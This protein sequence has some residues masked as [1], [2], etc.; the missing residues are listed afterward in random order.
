[1]TT[2]AGDV[3]RELGATTTSDGQHQVDAAL[4]GFGDVALD[5]LNLVFLEEGLA[6]R[7]T[8]SGQ[9][10][11]GHAAADEE[12]VGLLQ[13]VGDDAELVGDLGAAEDDAVGALGVTGDL[14]QGLD[15]LED[16]QAGGRGQQLGNVV[17][18][19]LLAVDDTEAVG[20]EGVAELGVLAGQLLALFVDLGGLARVVADVL[21]QGDLALTQ[22]GNR[23][24]SGGPTTSEASVTF[25]PDSSARRVATGA[26]EKAG[27][28]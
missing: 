3:G 23:L 20:D 24:G 27:S 9:E 2:V 17:D 11:E 19:R 5:G 7:V 28:T 18:G 22:G 13:Q 1:M 6:D 25:T 21:E 8:L 14:G 12:H 4:G 16:E 15:L 10:G 26:S